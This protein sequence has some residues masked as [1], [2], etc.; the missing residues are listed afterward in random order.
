MKQTEKK[1]KKDKKKEINIK[2]II[3][4]III[5]L[6][7]LLTIT[8]IR[9]PDKEIEGEK[10]YEFYNGYIFKKLPDFDNVWET[11]VKVNGVDERL[12]LRY[13][14]LDLENIE[15]NNTINQYFYLTQQANGH[16][17]ISLTKEIYTIESGKVSLAGFD[18]ARVLRSYFGYQIKTSV[19]DN[20]EY[21]WITCE[22]ATPQNLVIMFKKG[23]TKIDAE[24][25]CINLYFEDPNDSIKIVSLLLYNLLGIMN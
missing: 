4:T 17:T 15:Y 5:L 16:I 13:H 20:E 14:P 1:T 22:N 21:E 8:L 23:E 6:I 3:Y 19:E 18:L 11:E 25:F 10:N 24:P 7:I 9:S 2:P 12:E